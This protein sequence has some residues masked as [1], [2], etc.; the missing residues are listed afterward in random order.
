MTEKKEIKEIDAEETLKNLE[1]LEEENKTLKKE[2]ESVE[3]LRKEVERLEKELKE[4]QSIKQKEHKHFKLMAGV[5][6]TPRENEKF[7]GKIMAIYPM[8]ADSR[9]PH[10]R[11][12]LDF[13]GY[14]IT[15]E[16]PFLREVFTQ[17]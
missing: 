7:T 6:L 11:V 17:K 12:Q 13:G 14:F 3:A 16:E 4:N 15:L 2:V 1:R 5:E 8:G 9:Y 10:T